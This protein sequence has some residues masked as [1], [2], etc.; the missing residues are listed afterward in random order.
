MTEQE[1]EVLLRRYRPAGPRPDLRARILA[2]AAPVPRSWPWAAAAAALLA[3]VCF[4]HLL[5]GSLYERVGE[6][7]PHTQGSVLDRFPALQSAAE[8]D[9]L[10]EARLEALAHQEEASDGPAAADAGASWR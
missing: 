9:P 3:M 1:I 7:F 4:T 2:D 10:L 5:T 6:S 8:G